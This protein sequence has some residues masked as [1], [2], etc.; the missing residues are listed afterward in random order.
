MR[1]VICLPRGG[2]LCNNPAC[3]AER[4]C[5]LARRVESKA[6]LWPEWHP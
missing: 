2:V 1:E 5:R 3:L 4:L 6:P